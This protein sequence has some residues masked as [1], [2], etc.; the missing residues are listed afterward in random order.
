MTR[1]GTNSMPDLTSEYLA[2]RD[3]YIEARFTK[4]NPMQRQA[5][6]TTEGPLLILAGAGSG[7]TTVLVNRIANI[8]RFGSAHGSKELARPV[9]EQD[10]DDLRTAVAAGRDLPRETAYLAV[11]P[12]RPW[13]VLAITFTNKA[14]GELKERLRAMLGETLGGDVFASTFHSACVRFLRRDAERI[15]FPK[16]FT[17]YDSDDQQRVIKQIYKDLMIDDKFLP[18]KSAVSQISSFKDK[19]LSAEDIASE[20][21]RDTKAA[22]ISKIYTTYAA[23][24]KKAGAM[25]FDDLIY[26]TV[27]LL[28]NDEEARRYYQDKFKY[29]VVDEYQDTSIAQF[30]LV[31]LLAGG[32]NNVCVVGDD[33]QSIYKFR[34]ATIENILNF[35]QVFKGAKTIRLE[36][37]YRSTS[38]ILNAAN[39]V[40]KNNA[41]RKGK[42]LWTQNGD[43]EKVHHYTASNEQ[44]EASHL[45]DIIGEH[46]REGAHLR[47][48]A[49][50]YRMNAQSNPIE[51]YFARAGIP[52]R[53]VGGQRFFDRKEVK[54][55]NSYL[56][57]IVN[58]RDD[59]RLRRIINEPARK[60]GATTIEKIGDL[61]AK[62]GVP[63]LEIIGHVREYPE[64]QRAAAPL[65]KFY[66]MYRELCDLSVTL[67]LDEFAGEV[68]KKSGYEA[69][70]KAQ[71]EEG[72]TRLENLGQL[73]SSVKTYVDQNGEDATLAGFLEEV[74]LISDLDS[75]D[76]DADSVTMMT[77][78]SAKGLEFPYVF[79][80]GM[81]DGVFPGDMARYNE[82]DMEEERRLCYVAITRAKKE[83]YLSS[84]RSRL[85]FGQTRRNPPSTFLSEIDPD[86]LDET[87]S[88]ELACSGG[89][90]GAGYG[91]YSTNVP[92]GRS[93]YSGASRGYLNSEYNARPRGGFGGGYSSGFAS[94]GHES[95]NYSGGRHNVQSTGFGTGYGRSNNPHH[96]TPAGAGTSTLAGTPSATPKKK[97]A[98]SYAP[99]DLV[100][101][102]VFGKG[103]VIKATPIAGDCIVEIQF[104]RVGVK[105][106]MANY[107]PLKKLTEE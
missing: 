13:N 57:V 60:I 79:V 87:Q 6:F 19:L 2:L 65:E 82:E 93:G 103:K 41:G 52:Y 96:A 94:G 98:V 106:T 99:G 35:E 85:I 30:N 34:G 24:L 51:T 45:A 12:A 67:P 14:A 71:K 7:K 58:P 39:S 76:Q 8:I 31:R 68:V 66:E 20:A 92:G 36:Q 91:S 75:Y 50:L 1:K 74:A 63:M 48:H 26:H 89:G 107:A 23:R 64:L 38:N 56:A 46:L 44:D 77:I 9:T 53:I 43:G 55:I 78:H 4:L 16:S 21:P 61:A 3:Q 95:P 40:I 88:P 25:D 100:E 101:H 72:Q 69:M 104:D 105:K 15:G 102:R 80:V 33:D 54:D 81:E 28:Q 22:L 86:L 59:V 84:S 47:D 73:I 10:L 62:N 97:E 37:N 70:L 5:V 11:R 32:S 90:F 17:I 42:T 18:V 83:L 49:V 29:V 27:K